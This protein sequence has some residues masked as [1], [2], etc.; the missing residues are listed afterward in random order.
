MCTF[1]PNTCGSC[2][3]MRGKKRG[4]TYCHLTVLD[5]RTGEMKMVNPETPA[6]DRYE[7]V[8]EATYK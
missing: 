7:A 6:C 3:G 2:P 1:I 5:E 8:V 4:K